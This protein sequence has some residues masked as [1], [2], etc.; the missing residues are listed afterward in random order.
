MKMHEPT[1][2]HDEPPMAMLALY[3]KEVELVGSRSR[4]NQNT[5]YGVSNIFMRHGCASTGQ[6]AAA[7]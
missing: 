6:A 1:T 2:E 5:G 7:P 4:W 3:L